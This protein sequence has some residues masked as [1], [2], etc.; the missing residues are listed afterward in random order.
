[1]RFAKAALYSLC[2]AVAKVYILDVG[3]NQSTVPVVQ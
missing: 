1:M 2:S 3:I